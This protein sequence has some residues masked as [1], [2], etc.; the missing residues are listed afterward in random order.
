M[1]S[2]AGWSLSEAAVF[3][4][5]LNWTVRFRSVPSS[6]VLSLFEKGLPAVDLTS[7]NEGF[8]IVA[9]LTNIR[10]VLAPGY[11]VKKDDT[12]RFNASS[13]GV[14]VF[15]MGNYY[16]MRCFPATGN[17]QLPG[18]KRNDLEDG[19]NVLRYWLRTLERAGLGSPEP[20]APVDPQTG[21]RG[22][23]LHNE[24]VSLMNA[25]FSLGLTSDGGVYSL[26]LRNL[27]LII[28]SVTDAPAG[29]AGAGDA[30]KG[31]RDAPPEGTAVDPPE[32]FRIQMVSQD[33]KAQKLTVLFIRMLEDADGGK[34]RMDVTPQ[35]GI[36]T[37][38]KFTLL[39]EKSY[40]HISLIRNF[41][42]EVLRKNPFLVRDRTGP[43]RPDDGEETDDEAV[44]LDLQAGYMM[45]RCRAAA[46]E[47]CVQLAT[48][49]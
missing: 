41:F 7:V 32:P 38:G 36:N 30:T 26:D 47:F 42:A 1:S 23:V 22:F 44:D 21:T 11:S 25:K 6:V 13:V 49:S 3:T 34:G 37:S 33:V 19:R 4:A 28:D 31:R 10:T 27:R 39:G 5:T 17:H 35:V 48:K 43:S 29:G 12:S 9:V 24:K 14:H 16:K 46:G 15:H 40:A 20:G 2:E 8:H 45:T 18:I